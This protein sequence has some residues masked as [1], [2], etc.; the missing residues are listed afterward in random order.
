VGAIKLT[1]FHFSGMY[2]GAFRHLGIGDVLKIVK[3]VAM[4]AA[5]STIVLALLPHP[6]DVFDISVS[7]LDFYILL[8]LIL[9]ARCSFQ[10]LNYL[11]RQEQAGN[12]LALIY[13]ANAGGVLVLQQILAERSLN[14]NPVGFL[15]DSPLK[16]SPFVEQDEN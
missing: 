6:W 13:G 16:T 14:L 3:A 1:V 4:S 5:I 12:K 7:V 8:S 9:S 10:V 11:F 2:R 15:D